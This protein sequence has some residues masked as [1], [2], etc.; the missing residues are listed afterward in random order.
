[1][2]FNHIDI[3]LFF[4]FQIIS[5]QFKFDRFNDRMDHPNKMLFNHSIECISSFC[6]F[7][8]TLFNYWYKFCYQRFH[9]KL[10]PFQ[11]L[12]FFLFFSMKLIS[13]WKLFL[14]TGWCESKMKCNDAITFELFCYWHI[15]LCIT[16]PPQGAMT[17]ADFFCT[18]TEPFSSLLSLSIA[19]FFFNSD[20]IAIW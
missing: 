6:M 18:N 9:Q 5:K 14:Y 3:N 2:P 19:P 7:F 17:A 11:W 1:M 12:K 20:V 13:W 4:N 10:H 8:R 15:A 16:L